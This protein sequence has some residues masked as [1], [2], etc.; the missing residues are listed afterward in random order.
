MQGNITTLQASVTQ[1]AEQWSLLKQTAAT[2]VEHCR[3]MRPALSTYHNLNGRALVTRFA[4][5]LHR[6]DHD[7]EDSYWKSF[8]AKNDTPC[9]WGAKYLHSE[10]ASGV[11]AIEQHRL[12]LQLLDV[13]DFLLVDQKPTL[14]AL[15]NLVK[16]MVDVSDNSTQGVVSRLFGC[17]VTHQLPSI[18]GALRIQ[19]GQDGNHYAAAAPRAAANDD[20]TPEELA[21]IQAMIDAR[22]GASFAQRQAEEDEELALAL[23]MSAMWAQQQAHP[24]G[25]AGSQPSASFAKPEHARWAPEPDKDQEVMTTVMASSVAFGKKQARYAENDDA[26]MRIV[27]QMSLQM[28]E[29]EPVA[30]TPESTPPTSELTPE[31]H[32]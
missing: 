10:T 9:N 30:P 32:S 25:L 1:V 23:K 24:Q 21:Q 18:V 31:N 20:V 15:H 7:L 11:S 2:I 29:P 4:T 8:L 28:A 26:I 27:K 6:N 17:I 16:E 14:A 22:H 13:Q 3:P 12:F 19:S 5:V